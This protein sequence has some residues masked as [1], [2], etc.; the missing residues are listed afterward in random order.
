[1]V[2]AI[3]PLL[4]GLVSVTEALIDGAKAVVPMF[5]GFI[6][7]VRET[8]FLEVALG[9]LSVKGLIMGAK[10][11]TAYIAKLGG[12]KAVF[13]R[14]LPFIFK[15]IAP[16]LILEDLL[17][18][19]TGGKSAIGELLDKAFGP[20]T[21]EKIQ[22][23]IAK[24][25]E[26]LGLTDGFRNFAF[27]ALGAIEMLGAGADI[28]WTEMK[29]AGLAAAA[30]ISDGFMGAWNSV[31]DGAEIALKAVARVTRLIPG[32]D[33]KSV[34]EAA[35]NISALKGEANA[36]AAVEEQYQAARAAI[37]EVVRKIGVRANYGR[38]LEASGGSAVN[39]TNSNVIQINMPPGTTPRQARAIG[40]AAANGVSQANTT[41]LRA[42]RE[43]LVPR[44]A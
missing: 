40:N 9:A 6:R 43:A 30:A 26:F 17:S 34:S 20:G 12:L 14:L 2:Q 5:R 3:G 36:G 13:M 39:Q 4:P 32:L 10:A 18:F 15:V 29:F 8:K 28:V 25:A 16:L 23:I 41:N 11:L 22:A 7:F 27:Q 37:T 31:I 35:G 21:G 38:A 1:M 44:P 42:T 19:A 33:G 24:I